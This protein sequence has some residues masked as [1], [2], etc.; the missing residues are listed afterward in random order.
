MKDNVQA[1]FIDR[2]G[3]IGG[4][5]DV[6]Y[7]G[8]FKLFP[9][10]AEA[11]NILKDRKIKLYAFTNQPGISRGEALI[12]DFVKELTDF[13]FDQVY[14]CPHTPASACKCRKPETELLETAALKNNLDLKKCVV[15][16]DRWSDMLAAAKVGAV[17]ILVMTGAGKD[18][19][20]KYRNKWSNYQPD[21]IAEN[22]L[23][24]IRWLEHNKIEE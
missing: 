22:I 11:I 17:K 20:G 6:I 9:Y 5:N 10:T 18:A 24:A 16:G 4:S 15:I 7:P 13:G 14:I 21:F 12:E 19:V 2:D 1:V 3:T 23:E 8:D